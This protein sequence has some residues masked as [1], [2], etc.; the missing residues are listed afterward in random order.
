MGAGIGP[1]SN[2]QYFSIKLK[3]NR[4][5]RIGLATEI[6]DHDNDFYYYAFEDSSD[7]RRYW[8]D[9]NFHFYEKKFKNFGV[10]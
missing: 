4:H 10:P 5:Q 6:I 3:L 8:K 7:F 1:G 2:S 9:F